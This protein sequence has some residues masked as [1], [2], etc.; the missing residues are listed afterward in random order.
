MISPNQVLGSF[1]GTVPSTV[2]N[3]TQKGTE[4]AASHD[5]LT[6]RLSR[7]LSDFREGGI[8]GTKEESRMTGYIYDGTRSIRQPGY[9]EVGKGDDDDDDD[10]EKDEG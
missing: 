7:G 4:L 3:A 10:D 5:P 2:S 6:V 8:Y 1:P 9:T